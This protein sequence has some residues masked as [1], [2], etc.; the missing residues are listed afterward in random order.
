MSD[1]AKPESK[2]TDSKP[3]VRPA[4][5]EAAQTTQHTLALAGRTLAYT[6]TAG[7]LNLKDE[8]GEDRA[9]LFYVSYVLDGVADPS[10]RPVT[11]CFNGGPGSSSVWLHLGAFGPR[12]VVVPDTVPA[13]A[14]PH[15][16]EDNSASL[17]DQTD[18]VFID[19][20]GTGFSRPV[21]EGEGKHYW[22]VKEDV[23]SVATFILRWLNRN[24]RWTSPKLLAGESYGTTRAA[25]LALALSEKGVTLNGLILVS[26][27]LNFQTFLF[28]TGNDLPYLL[29]LP[30]YAATAWY[31]GRVPGK[32]LQALLDEVRAWTLDV[33]APALMRG[34]RLSDKARAAVAARLARYT[35]LPADAIA[36]RD[37]RIPYLWFAKQVLG[38]P[39]VTAGRLD[40]R[41]VGRDTDPWASE[42]TRDPSYD[43]IYGA[44][45]AGINETLR[46]TL[47]WTTDDEYDVLSIN[48][49]QDWRWEQGRRRGYLNV[50]DDLSQAMVA[51][52]HM[53]VLLANGLYDLATP[54]FAA[55]YTADHLNI[56]PELRGNVRLTW[57][58]AGHMMYL[59]PPS[60]LQLKADLDA[61]Y[62][63]VIPGS[64]A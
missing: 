36:A 11:F 61:F 14:A 38:R 39:G 62:R 37:L 1:A 46:R 43:A 3:K 63:D 19:P 16:L 15:R 54:F 30:S 50:A 20:V 9:S 18:L 59:H 22:S 17:L 42:L 5:P 60:L 41:Y 23:E 47:G 28:E 35:G 57:Y 24:G 45:T 40:S 34:P 7:T 52:P 10:T 53:G 31:H 2:P 25:G 64:Q 49:N 26:V 55:E 33:Y 48:V 29:Y 4:R 6:A 58:E 12:R 51:N 27:A 56:G 44:Y 8:Y 32:S 13:P 21:G